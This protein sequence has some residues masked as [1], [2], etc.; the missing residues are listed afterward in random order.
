MFTEPL[1]G[2]GLAVPDMT[3]LVNLGDESICT[4]GISNGC[5]VSCNLVNDG[6]VILT[7]LG[8]LFEVIGIVVEGLGKVVVLACD[9]ALLVDDDW[10]L[11]KFGQVARVLRI[12]LLV[13]SPA[14]CA[15]TP[16]GLHIAY[17]VKFFDE[18][19]K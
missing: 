5:N 19:A 14:D 3:I 2:L 11:F 8:L 9:A 18:V 15:L 12:I 4:V 7:N 13:G 6:V 10:H 1:A 17:K 16:E